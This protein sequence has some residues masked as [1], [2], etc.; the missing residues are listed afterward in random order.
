MLPLEETVTFEQERADRMRGRLRWVLGFLLAL[1]CFAFV[2][3]DVRLYGS[4]TAKL[5]VRVLEVS[6]AVGMLLW[7]RRPRAWGAIEG[8][9]IAGALAIIGV[10]SWTILWLPRD[11][12]TFAVASRLL[13]LTF[14]VYVLEFRW[15]ASAVAHAGV[16]LLLVGAYLTRERVEG[17]RSLGQA[18]MWLL[19]PIPVLVYS[20]RRREVQQRSAFDLEVALGEANA[21][22]QEEIA[23]RNRLYVQL[24]HDLRTPLAVIL[25]ESSLLAKGAKRG[26]D[27]DAL[28]RVASSARFAT[29]LCERLLEVARLEAG[30]A[31]Y[32]PGRI[33]LA[34]VVA[35]VC[36]ELQ[37]RGGAT[38]AWSGAG[39]AEADAGH[40]RR[41]LMNL[42][43]N[44]LKAID[45][46]RGRVDVTVSLDPESL[47]RVRIDVR[48]DGPGLP[49]ELRD[50]PFSRGTL[51]AEGKS[52]PSGVG[53]P[54]AYELAT[55]QG[56][57]LRLL[58]S[59]PTTFRLELPASAKAACEEVRAIQPPDD[60]SGA[61][62]PRLLIVEDTPELMEVLRRVF[63][64][65]FKVLE[66]GSLAEGRAALQ[67]RP[68][69]VL[70]DVM[71]PDGSG[72]TLL[73][74]LR[75]D[76]ESELPFVF[77]S[78]LG[79]PMERS[80]GILAGADD[81]VAKPF[82]PTELVV[83]VER[84]L[85]RTRKQR[86][87]VEQQRQRLLMELH[88]GV[89]SNLSRARL[90]LGAGDARSLAAASKCVGDALDETR[91]AFALIDGEGLSASELCVELRRALTDIAES[92]GLEVVCTRTVT[93]DA[94]LSAATAHA[95]RRLAHEGLTNVMRHAAAT[96]VW[97]T[98][99]AEGGQL[100]VVIEDDGKG[101]QPQENPGRGLALAHARV[102][103]VGGSLAVEPR[104]GGGTRF[105]ASMPV[106]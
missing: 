28:R 91:A 90:L 30:G 95:A 58:A 57:T 100:A 98:L 15:K 99:T 22:L 104:V 10:T 39:V 35:D 56:G 1:W 94:S 25:A 42:V 73:E 59:S 14:F 66:A 96:R 67:W 23:R 13:L 38:L 2:F 32:H 65:R 45:P 81:Y 3:A 26:S 97:V 24:N 48:D 19:V 87:E 62:P 53:L 88:D 16:L 40:V 54:L 5:G 77:L 34:Q 70:C 71:L 105:A 33:A 80:R 76:A 43:S 46:E 101:P 92:H 55:L 29:E 72:F 74:E 49:A 61:L 93:V 102:A 83:R 52:A 20:A 103:R 60:P 64:E 78:A 51:F 50:S 79:D 36:A 44:A 17:L 8:V 12:V 85:A 86:A 63:G 68:D 84:A 7:L 106:R 37:P 6:W 27:H 11:Q 9:T 89:S 82:V 4:R 41:I 47:A 75:R 21:H 31:P 18:A 69:V